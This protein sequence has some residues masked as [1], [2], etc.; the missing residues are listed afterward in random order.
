MSN[1]YLNA[2]LQ[3]GAVI[4]YIWT[5]RARGL[6]FD[7]AQIELWQWL[8]FLVLCCVGQSLNVGIYTAIGKDGVYYGFKLGKKIPW[9]NGFPFN[10]VSHPQYVGSAMTVWGVLALLHNQLPESAKHITAF[11]TGLYV[12]TGLQ[13]Q[14]L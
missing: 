1:H 6:C 12:V 8:S 2:A 4:A 3:F 7:I 5:V 9:V 10:V 13:E 11:W 14:F